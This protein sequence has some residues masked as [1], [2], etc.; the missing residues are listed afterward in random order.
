MIT[1]FHNKIFFLPDEGSVKVDIDGMVI[2][3]DDS[4][5]PGQHQPVYGTILGVPDGLVYG[6]DDTFQ[7]N[8]P[9]ELQVGDRVIAGFYDIFLA[10]EEDHFYWLDGQRVFVTRYD[11]VVVAFRDN[12]VIPC[13]G[14]CIVRAL[15]P[16]DISKWENIHR[17]KFRH[18]QVLGQVIHTGV[19]NKE[20]YYDDGYSDDVDVKEGDVIVFDKYCDIRIENK[21]R[22]YL[23][24][25]ATFPIQRRHILGIIKN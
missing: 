11:T 24:Q 23:F 5:E 8:T 10:L 9:M 15:A 22:E 2:R 6:K 1:P 7:W 13:N 3:P 14:Y 21:G 4:Y 16:E 19:P 25:D 20:Y 17:R 12:K 18:D